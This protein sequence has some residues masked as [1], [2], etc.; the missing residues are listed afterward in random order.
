MPQ[1]SCDPILILLSQQALLPYTGDSSL[2]GALYDGRI[3]ES[4]APQDASLAYIT[5]AL[6]SEQRFSFSISKRLSC[7]G[8]AEGNL[9]LMPAA[10]GSWKKG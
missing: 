7:L 5:T 2:P 4:R 10:D 9:S 6:R 8:S 1:F 3:D